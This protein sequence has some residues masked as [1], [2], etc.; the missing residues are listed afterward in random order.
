MAST[1]EL[2]PAIDL[3]AGRVVRLEQGDF[4]RETVFGDDPVAIARAFAEA[5]AAWLHVVDLDG[6]RAGEPTQLGTVD[7]IVGAVGTA[8]AVEAAGGIRSAAAI[9]AA[10]A[11][12]AIRVVLGTAAVQNPTL[13]RDAV[14]VHGSPAIAI[15]LDV[16]AG[17][18]VG[19]AWQSGASGQDPERLI[20]T[21]GELGATTF[22]V[23]A[24][25]RDGLLGGP[26]LDLLR[27]LTSVGG[28]RVIASGGIRDVDDVLAV[29][30]LGC[31]GAIVGR[32]LYNGTFDLRA[33]ISALEA[34]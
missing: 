25:D 34:G 11:T 15:A 5:G 20:E 32:A 28:G 6:A 10:I 21:L 26:D 14:A 7:A 19:D 27:R 12:G 3:R 33:A 8:T 31:A 13:V 2:M 1:F 30:N 24:I 9:G 4:A 17:E 23:T 16:R 18:A 29:R 22:E